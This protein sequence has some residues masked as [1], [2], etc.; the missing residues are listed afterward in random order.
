VM[1]CQPDSSRQQQQPPP[2][3]QQQPPSIT[4][5]TPPPEQATRERTPGQTD[6]EQEIA[7]CPGPPR[8]PP[9]SGPQTRATPDCSCMLAGGKRLL[10]AGLRMVGRV[11]L[12]EGAFARDAL[13]G[14]EMQDDGGQDVICT[15][16]CPCQRRL[17]IRAG[18][19]GSP[20]EH[21]D[22]GHWS[23]FCHNAEAHEELAR[24]VRQR[25][26]VVRRNARA[27]REG[28][29]REAPASAMGGQQ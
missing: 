27:A 9:E 1:T 11:A 21:G 22:P 4:P 13:G 28:L 20:C 7:S 14:T 23:F 2:Q 25:A 24:Q 18:R 16:A 3:P 26:R 17:C 10:R 6:G 5:P 8:Q 12:R 19:K 29:T 15:V